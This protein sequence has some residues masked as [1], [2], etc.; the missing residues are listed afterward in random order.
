[1]TVKLT[2]IPFFGEGINAKSPVVTRQRRLNCYYE[3]RKDGDKSKAVLYGTPGMKLKFNLTSPNN[4]PLRGILGCALGLFCVVGS[5]F[6]SLSATGSVLFSASITT[7]NGPVSFSFNNTQILLVDGTA[8]WTFTPGTS[9]FAQIGGG[10]PSGALSATFLN[11]FFVCELPG[12]QEFFVS[13]SGDG[14]T[15]SA[16]AFASASQYPDNILA[17]D[18]LQGLLVTFSQN[19]QEFW[20]NIGANPEPF[21]YI[22]NS[23]NEFGLAAVFSRA[24]IDNSI[25]FLTNTR[26][27]GY[28]VAVTSGYSTMIASTPD[29]DNIIQ[30]LSTVADAEAMVYQVDSHK[31]YQLTF[32]TANR[33]IVYDVTTNIWF[34]AQT[35]ITPNYAQRHIGRFSTLYQG[36]T[37]VTD[38]NVGNVYSPD[39]NTFTDNGAVIPREV[40]TRHAVQD[41]NQFRVS[42]VYLDM[43]TGVGLNAGQGSNPQIMVNASKDNGRTFG[44]ERW[45]GVGKTGQYMAR[46]TLRRITRGRDVVIRFRM[47]DPVKFVVTDG[48]AIISSRRKAA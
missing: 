14:T 22:P 46:P 40:T 26:E 32:P 30:S 4:N 48:A 11:S 5:T 7:G 38:Y 31:F 2:R 25:M 20:Q 10:F 16:L 41:F 9:T 33:T 45:M 13:N 43:E 42:S 1:M 35:G 17:V 44:I 12:T 39:V 3:F 8:G 37:L 18:A 15:W 36:K 27:G 28:Q 24:H 34:E 19:H 21:Q 23:A 47:T 6:Y 29:I